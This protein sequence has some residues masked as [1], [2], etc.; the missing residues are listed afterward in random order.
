MTEQKKSLMPYIGVGA[1]TLSVGLI[2]GIYL[3][4]SSDNPEPERT[5]TTEPAPS[6]SAAEVEVALEESPKE[7]VSSSTVPDN[8][9]DPPPEPLVPDQGT[10]EARWQSITDEA[11]LANYAGEWGDLEHK[12]TPLVKLQYKREGSKTPFNV[13]W[14]VTETNSGGCGF[15][16]KGME[17]CEQG[18]AHCQVHDRH[19]R[20]IPRSM[21]T[22]VKFDMQGKFLRLTIGEAGTPMDLR[23]KK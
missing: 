19:N 5:G 15:C 11:T 21:K 17:D 2:V 23:R 3:P 9:P 18:I 16:L 20:K 13:Q 12:P 6:A 1:I 22:T 14:H 7:E 10:T 4:P 8:P